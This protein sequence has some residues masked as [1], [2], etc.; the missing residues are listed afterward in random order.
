MNLIPSFSTET[1][2]LLI[3]FLTLLIL[4]G[5]WPY[6]FFKKLGIPG[7]RPLPFVG[8]LLS[9]IWG[10]HNFDVQCFNK[11]GS[12]WGIFDGRQPLLMITDPEMI[13]SVMV[14][15][16]YTFFTNRRE[17]VL[18]GPL[19]DALSIV[20]DEKW[21]R[22]RS[23]MSPLFTSGRLKEIFPIV[24][25]YAD[26]LI[27]NL[28]KRN[29]ENPVGIK[30]IFGPYSMDVVT[31]TSFSVD[32][33]SINNPKDPFVGNVKK[34]MKFSLFNPLILILTLFPFTARFFE[35]LGVSFVSKSSLDYFYGTV[36]K[37]KDE[38]HINKESRVDFLQLMVRSQILEEKANA[39]ESIKPVRGLTDHE[40]L[41]Q[42]L[43]FIVGGYETTSSTL[44]LLAHNLATNPTAM[45]KL[46]EE[47]DSVFPNNTP[48]TYEALMQME[49]LDM[50][51]NESMRLWPPAPRIERA[52]K[53]TVEIQGVTIP[54]GTLVVVPTYVLH[55]DP[56]IW[57][58]PDTYKPE[59]FSKENREDI[60]PYTFLPFG[61]GPRN[62][63]G[64]RFALLIMKMVV[65]KLLQNFSLETCK[66]TQIPLQL[67]TLFQ[68]K[69]P[70]TL[71][72]VPRTPATKQE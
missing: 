35:K 65:V 24:E 63:I 18:A 29:L 49:Y 25:R 2:T 41:S 34:M 15:E 37:I 17:V 36:R 28:K 4:Y 64:M 68:P 1:W 40:I 16:C 10:F 45:K 12:I 61:M 42:S 67:N 27:A 38:H 31:S 55:R 50:A 47:I 71:K 23:S 5:V 66:E 48:V 72:I 7:P 62:C 46:Q 26:S 6:G 58:S 3:A 56:K 19:A 51:M 39:Q 60:N 44:S 8:T 53:N 33:D 21:K 13:K 11:Y 9:Y 54:T 30:D 22:I 14:K 70:I 20:K 43:V 57:E 59:R 32:I 52:C 69:T